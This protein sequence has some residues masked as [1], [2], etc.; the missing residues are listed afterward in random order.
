[1]LLTYKYFVCMN[2][3][4]NQLATKTMSLIGKFAEK[5]DVE[6]IQQLSQTATKIKTLQESLAS[7]EHDATKIEDYLNGFLKAPAAIPPSI[8]L[9][10][11]QEVD[12]FDRV[13]R[14]RGKK[15][16][17]EINWERLQK[18]GGREIICEHQA[19][20]T[21]TRFIQ[22]LFNM[23]GIAI[24]EKLSTLRI[25]RGPIVS[26]DPNKDFVNR[27]N[28]TLYAHQ[29]LQGTAYHVLT[30]SQTSQKIGDLKEVCRYLGFPVG[31]VVI[32]EV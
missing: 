13:G 31:A 8:Y 5:N 3:K 16:R 9:Q 1:M 30:H 32:T 18:P 23:N 27:A 21:M 4:L 22:R 6:S 26:K 2:T 11:P 20:E 17:V 14:S 7:I 28:G 10:T 24:L 12:E 25:S 15:L 29:R 19:S